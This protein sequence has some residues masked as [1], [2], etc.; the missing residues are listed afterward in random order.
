MLD[1]EAE[2]RRL[3][4][5]GLACNRNHAVEIL[6]KM[7]ER[8]KLADLCIFFT[9]PHLVRASF[10]QYMVDERPY[11]STTVRVATIPSGAM[12]QVMREQSSLGALAIG[13]LKEFAPRPDSGVSGVDDE[14]KLVAIIRNF[15]L[16][17][18]PGIFL[19][20]YSAEATH[21][22]GGQTFDERE[23]LHR[24]EFEPIGGDFVLGM[25]HA[26]G[27]ALKG[28]APLVLY[29]SRSYVMVF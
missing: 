25:F 28:R 15:P 7:E 19:S 29:M 12:S 16:E 9:D 23:N 10:G 6:D 4:G 14:T 20:P 2:I 5:S 13:A 3:L 21:A 27:N 22:M 11:N 1:R 8:K 26:W 24:I 17:G 18:K